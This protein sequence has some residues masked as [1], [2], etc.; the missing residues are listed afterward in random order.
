[1][2]LAT[3]KPPTPESSTPMGALFIIKQSLLPYKAVSDFYLA[4]LNV[5][6]FLRNMYPGE[7]KLRKNLFICCPELKSDA[8]VGVSPKFGL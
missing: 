5:Q 4:R 8:M 2:A 3:V 7:Q 6:I 1:M